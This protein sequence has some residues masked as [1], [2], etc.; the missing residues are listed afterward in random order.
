MFGF[1]EFLSVVLLS[2]VGDL[3]E[4]CGM[5][6]MDDGQS[7]NIADVMFVPYHK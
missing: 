2:A 3:K 1:S 7:M 6:R 4:D 5:I